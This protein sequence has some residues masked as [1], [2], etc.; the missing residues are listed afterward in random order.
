MFFPTTFRLLKAIP[1]RPNMK[2]RDLERPPRWA[3]RSI[4]ESWNNS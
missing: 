4:Y 2:K 3:S 1:I